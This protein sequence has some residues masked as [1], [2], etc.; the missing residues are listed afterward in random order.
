MSLDRGEARRRI[1]RGLAVFRRAGIAPVGFVAPAWLWQD[2]TRSVAGSL[3]LPISED[4][5]AI[6]LHQRGTRLD[7]P[8]IRWSARTTARAATSAIV[9][10]AMTWLHQKHW[11]VRIALHP[12]DLWRAATAD[13]AMETIDWWRARRH[14]WSYS[15]L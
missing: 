12:T 1:Q 9:A 14:P 5:H 13:S 10:R 4:E 6:Y 7:S 8:V 15:A 2:H 11:L 3:G